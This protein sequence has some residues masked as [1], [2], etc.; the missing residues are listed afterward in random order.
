MEMEIEIEMDYGLIRVIRFYTERV[1]A[2]VAARW[3]RMQ[4]TSAVLYESIICG[5]KCVQKLLDRNDYD[6]IIRV[7]QSQSQ[8]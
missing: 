8:S 5:I 7:A 1:N 6:V 2:Q 4:T 3:R